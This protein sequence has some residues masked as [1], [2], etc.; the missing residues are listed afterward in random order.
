[1]I[2]VMFTSSKKSNAPAFDVTVLKPFL[3][4]T[5]VRNNDQVT[6]KVVNGAGSIAEFDFTVKGNTAIANGWNAAVFGAP[7]ANNPISLGVCEVKHQSS[8]TPLE[9]LTRLISSR[10]ASFKSQ[11]TSRSNT[12]SK[13][14][15][16]V[17]STT[18]SSRA[19]KK[20]TK[21]AIVRALKNNNGNQTAT[22][23]EFNVS[24]R[25]LG[26]WLDSYNL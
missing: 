14:K 26:R 13:T 16:T 7:S 23:Y 9:L 15:S 21:T 12:V 25:T 2:E 18:T 3:G 19:I 17:T 20:P 10:T 5:K 6:L 11:K 8:P 1:M 22:A 4:K 24:R